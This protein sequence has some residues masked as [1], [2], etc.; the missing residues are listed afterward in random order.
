MNYLA[1]IYL[2]GTDPQKQVGNFIGDAVKGSSYNNY[3]PTIREG[4]LLHRA[5]DSFTDNHPIIKETIGS[6]RPHFGRYSAILLDIYFDYLL[7]SRF[8]EFSAVSLKKFARRF[9]FALIRNR[10]HLPDR[11]K[12]FMWHFIGSNRL[13]KYATTEGIRESL[14]IMVH[15][16][17][18][19]ISPDEAIRYLTEHETELLAVFRPFFTE[20][21]GYCQEWTAPEKPEPDFG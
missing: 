16:K 12:R 9:Y 20:L 19:A 11:I 2:S 1:H 14:G 13:N 6:L 21:Q 8:S 15:Y 5:I 7:A 3:P 17:N 10:R 18:I 4:I